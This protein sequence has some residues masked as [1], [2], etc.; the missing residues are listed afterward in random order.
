[1]DSLIK[2]LFIL[3]SNLSTFPLVVSFFFKNTFL[4]ELTLPKRELELPKDL[5]VFTVL[6]LLLV[7]FLVYS[8]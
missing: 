2:S 3:S 1:M 6:S 5:E 7:F 8:V 4:L